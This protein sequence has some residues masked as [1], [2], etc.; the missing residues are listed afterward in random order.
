MLRCAARARIEEWILVREIVEA[1]FRDDLDD[2]QREIAQH[3]NRQLATGKE[4]LNQQAV[5]VLRRLAQRVVDLALLF[6]DV[7]ADRR[8]LLRRL[9]DKRQRHPNFEQRLGLA[10]LDVA[11]R[12]GIG[13]AEQDGREWVQGQRPVRERAM[14]IDRRREGG[15]LRQDE[16]SD[17]ND[18]DLTSQRVSL[19]GLGVTGMPYRTGARACEAH[20]SRRDRAACASGPGR[21][22]SSSR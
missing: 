7:G 15:G 12:Q 17:R 3:A 10:G 8:A 19:S 5:V 1:A 22:R 2:R 11:L 14:Q 4:F 16:R 18:H 9:Y 21:A 6:H 13:L 20:G